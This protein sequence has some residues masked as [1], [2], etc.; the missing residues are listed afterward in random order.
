MFKLIWSGAEEMEFP[1]PFLIIR[2]VK[3]VDLG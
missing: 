1:A 3:W 2:T